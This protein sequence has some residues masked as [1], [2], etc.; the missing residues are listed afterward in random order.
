MNYKVFLIAALVM[1]SGCSSTPPRDTQ[2]NTSMSMSYQALYQEWHG[3]PYQLGGNSKRGVDCS[4]FVQIAFEEL[5]RAKLP[6]TTQEQS[7][8]GNKIA[9]GQASEGDLVFFKTGYKTRHVG[10]YLGGNQ[11]LHA[12]TSRGVIISRLDNPYWADKFWH[13]RNVM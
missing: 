1:L 5:Y 3:V 2:H 8:I 11:F 4:A 7:Q 6:R 12:S 10:I 13:F 9:Y